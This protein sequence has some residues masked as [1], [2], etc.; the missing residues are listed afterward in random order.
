MP[1]FFPIFDLEHDIKM[2]ESIEREIEEIK[3]EV[4]RKKDE[5]R[6]EQQQQQQQ[7]QQCVLFDNIYHVDNSRDVNHNT[8]DNNNNNNNN[9]NFSDKKD[10]SIAV[11]SKS[12]GHVLRNV[13]R[14][15]NIDNGCQ[16]WIPKKSS[17]ASH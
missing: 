10:N 3:Q 16:Y 8:H 15:E 9:E 5:L 11:V 4:A 17:H 12:C 7:E 13:Y 6:R 14:Y 2:K 1:F